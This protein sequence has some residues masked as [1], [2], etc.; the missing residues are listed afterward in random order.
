MAQYG[1]IWRVILDFFCLSDI[2]GQQH[3]LGVWW[4]MGLALLIVLAVPLLIKITDKIGYFIIPLTYALILIVP[5]LINN[6]ERIGP[7]QGYYLAAVLGVIAARK[8]LLNKYTA[9]IEKV[10]SGFTIVLSLIFILAAASLGLT[11]GIA[12]TLSAFYV[13]QLIKTVI[14]VI[15]I[16][17]CVNIAKTDLIA[18]AMEFMGSLSDDMFIIHI[19]INVLFGFIIW[20]IDIPIVIY[21]LLLILSIIFTWIFKQIK[22]LAGYDKLVKIVS[23]KLEFKSR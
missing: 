13:P 12:E 8:G 5:D 3:I 9:Y 17:L 4:Y 23:S 22:K 19:V 21:S 11:I 2:F 6:D 10:S 20:H 18:K 15:I 16:L 7:Y 1:N 14:A